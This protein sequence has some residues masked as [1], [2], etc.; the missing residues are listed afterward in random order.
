MDVGAIRSSIANF[1]QAKKEIS[2]DA[3]FIY[4]DVDISGQT[5]ATAIPTAR[6]KKQWVYVCFR[7][8]IVPWEGKKAVSVVLPPCAHCSGDSM[9]VE[10]AFLQQAPAAEGPLK[11]YFRSGPEGLQILSCA[12]S[13]HV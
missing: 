13:R 5:Y 11:S 2:I 4:W 12:Q 7:G 6:R 8:S 1:W 10:R 9:V 3:W